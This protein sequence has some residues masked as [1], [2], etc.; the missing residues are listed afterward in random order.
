[1]GNFIYIPIIA[2]CCYAFLMLALMA[3]K[4]TRIINAFL[5]VLCAMILW[6]SGSLLMR[7]QLFPSIKFW[8]DISI[9]G[10]T[11]MPYT[12][13][14]FAVEYVG[15]TSRGFMKIWLVLIAIANVLN[16]T[17]EVFLAHPEL[18]YSAGG[19]ESFVYHI[20]WPVTILFAL[21]GAIVVHMLVILFNYSTTNE[22]TKK[23]FTPI[24]TGIIILFIGHIALMFPFFQGFPTDIL[25]GVANALFMF[26]ALYKR[27]LFKLTLLV[28]RGSS[29]AFAAI[30]SLLLFSNSIRY[31]ERF[32][33]NNLPEFKG[34]SVL[35][36]AFSF[37][38]A[39]FLIYTVM[40]KFIDKVFTKDEIAQAESLKEFSMAVSKSLNVNEILEELVNVIQKSISVKKVYVCIAEGEEQSYTIAHST[41]ALDK[42]M[43]SIHKDNPV[44]R[45]L[46]VNNGCLLMK[47]FR[48]T[49][50]FKSM[51]EEEKSQLQNLDIECFVPLKDGDDLV[52]IVLLTGKD[53][54]SA[55]TYDDLSLLSSVD[56]IGSIAVKNSRL[57]EKAYLEARTDELTGLLNRKYF[58]EVIQREYEK[59]RDRSL[60]LIILNIDDF[61]LYNQLYGNKEGDLALQNIAR[62]IRASVGDNGYVARYSGKEFAIILPL[63]DLLAARNLAETIRLQIL[64]MNKRTTQDCFKMLTVSAGICS[65]PY[66]ASSVRELIDHADMAI[67]HVKRNGKNAIM[68]YSL[69]EKG[70]VEGNA[71][72][73]GKKEDIYSEYATTI[74][75]LTAA[76]DTKDHYTFSHSKNVA[77]Y[78]TELAYAYGMN[79]ES[80]EIV[81]EAALLHDIGKIGVPEHILNKPGKL[82]AEEYDIMKGHVENSI[83]IIRYL[84]SLDYVIPA[85]IGHHERYDGHGYP[86]RI[87]RED[88]PLSARILC[89]ADSFDAMTS[90]RSYKEP[91][92]VPRALEIL[93]EQAGLQFDPKLVHIFIA[94]V[95]SGDIKVNDIEN[96]HEASILDGLMRT[97]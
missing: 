44:V 9:L 5:L 95:I 71:A 26:Y 92:T 13:Y 40:K 30:I 70:N 77:Y 55:F 72:S 83:G 51:W 43:F 62:I 57:Y 67:Y 86:R 61:K 47:D 6:T 53:R 68:V 35:I 8:Y 75:A 60:A 46:A 63:Y 76:I 73:I 49:I 38:I 87:A 18:A 2:L 41:S 20:S 12:F 58:Y 56:S 65:I 22:M 81:R 25:S 1:M 4:K 93:E 85:V 29:Y 16:V 69:G 23:Q 88:I 64:N 17:T 54:H 89:I 37:T 21:C 74:Y 14:I 15:A 79:Q 11:L 80:V 33:N 32:I 36:I 91:Y 24:I 28:S 42:K 48:R 31:L 90:Q 34:Y 39:T 10:L 84:P 94:G 50:A 97:S 45:W 3:A 27:R 19:Q 52:G 96:L 78:A 7:M 59:N 82:T 66:A